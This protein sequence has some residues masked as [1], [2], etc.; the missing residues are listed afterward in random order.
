MVPWLNRYRL[1]SWRGW[2][3]LYGPPCLA[4]VLGLL[5]LSAP[6]DA[7]PRIPEL[8]YRLE[9]VLAD[10]LEDA[11][12]VEADRLA[13]VSGA[14]IHQESLWRPDAQSPYAKGLTQFTPPTSE[15]I[16]EKFKAD[17]WPADPWDPY[18][19]IRAMVL[20][21]RWIYQRI[22]GAASQCDAW[23]MTLAA[24]NGGLGW[25]H[26]DRKLCRLADHTDGDC[27]EGRWFGHVERFSQR[28]PW[29]FRE[30]RGY[31][32]RILFNLT[33][34]YLRAGFTGTDFCREIRP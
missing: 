6:A 25:I 34:A 29:A 17:L 12:G 7:D 8:G 10:E 11:W 19:S 32:R 20:Y 5:A 26:R 9:S 24:Y 18:W 14:Q 27:H 1:D 23:A 16:A 3:A 28:A 4:I 2:F 33:P 22:R 31:P 13:A 30:N 21:D 15:W